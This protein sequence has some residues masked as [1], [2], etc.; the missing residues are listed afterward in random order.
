MSQ[1]CQVG[2]WTE[3]ANVINGCSAASVSR[4]DRS[5]QIAIHSSTSPA[6][7]QRQ[8]AQKGATGPDEANLVQPQP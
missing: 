1:D 7:R 3:G 6:V 4:C 5:R 8:A 2:R